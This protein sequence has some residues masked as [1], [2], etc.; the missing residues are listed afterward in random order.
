MELYTTIRTYSNPYHPFQV[1]TERR[2]IPYRS[3][4]M[5][6]FTAKCHAS[7]FAP[8]ALYPVFQSCLANGL[9]YHAYF[10]SQSQPVTFP[11]QPTYSNKKNQHLSTSVT[12]HAL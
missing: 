3:I 5:S 9:Q 6:I 10:E 8:N 1:L 12:G 11:S 4:S 2:A 7:N